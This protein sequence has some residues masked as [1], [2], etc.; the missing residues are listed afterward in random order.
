MRPLRRLARAFGHD[1]LPRPKL[2]HPDAQLVFM[3]ERFAID[4]VI[5]VGANEGQYAARLREWGWRG[6]IVSFEPIEEVHARLAAR[7]A[8][9][10]AW[11]VAPCTALGARTGTAV[12]HISAEPDMSSLLPQ[13]PLLREISPSSAVLRR[14]EVPLARLDEVALLDRPDWRRLFL[15]L[16]VQGFEPEVLAGAAGLMERIVGIQLEL[17]L[18]PLYQGER[19]WREML[20]RLSSQGFA[21]H[22]FIPGYFSRRL[23]R[24]VQMDGV[25][26]RAGSP[27]REAPAP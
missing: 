21:P 11:T 8:R 14:T 2:G 13:T 15:K 24:Q 5:D 7:A 6:P 18:L 1:L 19:D 22:L 16:D 12:L 10:P 23:A 3:L 20:D 9:D 17:A 26:F 27:V 25:F 4:V